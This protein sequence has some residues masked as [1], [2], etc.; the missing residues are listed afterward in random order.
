VKAKENGAV[1]SVDVKKASSKELFDYFAQI[2][3]NYDQDRVHASDIKKLITWYNILIN[4]GITE[5]KEEKPVDEKAE[6]AI[7]EKVEEEKKVEKEVTA[8]KSAIQK[9]S[10]KNAVK[11]SAK[12]AVKEAVKPAKTTRN[13]AVQRKAK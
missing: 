11:N 1:C 12:R 9:T 7:E 10:E 3:P 8:K 13:T 5:F 6:E 4:N 2:L